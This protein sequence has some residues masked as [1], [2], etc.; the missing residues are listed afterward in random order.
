MLLN[1][2]QLTNLL[3]FVDWFEGEGDKDDDVHKLLPFSKPSTLSLICG[4]FP[5]G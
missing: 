5:N 3:L 1:Q 4:F 2:D